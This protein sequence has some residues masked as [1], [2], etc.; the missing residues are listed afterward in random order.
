MRKTREEFQRDIDVFSRGANGF[1]PFIVD[2]LRGIEREYGGVDN[3]FLE[4]IG[5]KFKVEEKELLDTLKMLGIKL[6]T[7]KETK[8]IRVCIGMNCKAGGN[9]FVL[10]EFKKLLKIDIDEKTS[11]GSFSLA[12]QRCFAK[13]EE[14]PNVKVGDKFYSKVDVSKVKGIIEDNR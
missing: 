5:E 14:G 1:S 11:D 2:I 3:S 12:I 7:I 9:E 4:Y 8:E 10:E 6:L 13:C